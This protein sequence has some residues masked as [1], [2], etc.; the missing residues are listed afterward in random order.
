MADLAFRQ[1]QSN[2]GAQLFT[3]SAKHYQ[4]MA[5]WRFRHQMVNHLAGEYARGKV[6]TNTVKSFFGLLKR[7]LFGTYHHVSE[8][9]SL[10]RERGR[11]FERLARMILSLSRM[12]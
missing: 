4:V 7:G 5:P 3:D 9:G 6:H 8:G 2:K 11:L 1:G 12:S 10:F